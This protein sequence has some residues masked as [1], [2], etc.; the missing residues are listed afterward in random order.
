MKKN[1]YKVGLVVFFLMMLGFTIVSRIMDTIMTT[2]IITGRIQ[3]KNISTIIEGDAIIEMGSQTLIT[4][5]SGY[6]IGEIKVMEGSVVSPETEL[7]SYQLESIVRVRDSKQYELD[8]LLLE[9]AQAQINTQ[10]IQPVSEEEAA[11]MEVQTAQQ[12]LDLVKAKYDQAYVDYQE[13]VKLLDEKYEKKK[14]LSEDELRYQNETTYRSSRQNYESAKGNRNSEVKSAERKV[15]DAEEELEQLQEEGAE[16]AI[17]LAAQRKLKRAEDD[18][19]DI[20][21]AWEDQLDAA[22]S[23][24]IMDEELI[25]NIDSGW[26]S[27]QI[28]L[29][30]QYQNELKQELQLLQEAEQEVE[31][32]ARELELSQQQIGL[33]QKRDSVTMANSEKNRKL[34]GISKDAIQI[35]IDRK[36]SELEAVNELL[37]RGGIVKAGTHGTVVKLGI[38]SGQLITGE[39]SIQLATGELNIRGTFKKTENAS[40]QPGDEVNVITKGKEYT[41][42]ADVV[43]LFGSEQGEFIAKTDL[44]D[45]VLG[46]NMKFRYTGK[47]DIYETVLPLSAIHKDLK[48]FYCFIVQENNGISGKEFVAARVNIDVIFSGSKEAAVQGNLGIDSQ[49]IVESNAILQEGERVRLINENGGG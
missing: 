6:Q 18:L 36:R 37:D 29:E 46:M 33:S 23:Q 32:A 27:I 48:G 24:M 11:Q 19:A 21:D 38:E 45:V 3:R 8:K 40:I 9:F 5:T 1:I 43:N 15:A 12:S 7:F 28:S 44:E 49:I 4:C 16:E 14:A 22:E 35:D 30:E 2:Q 10:V 42:V 34:A 41:V 31:S 25:G 17:L 26:T 20:R 13:N 47:S 39:E